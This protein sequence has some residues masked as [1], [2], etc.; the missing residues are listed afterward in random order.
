M[1][2]IRAKLPQRNVRHFLCSQL[3]WTPTKSSQFQSRILCGD[4]RLPE[5]F[6][7]IEKADV[8]IT[9]PPYCLLERRRKGGDLREPKKNSKLAGEDTVPRFED[10]RKYRQFTEQWLGS[11]VQFGLKSNAMLV[12]WSNALGKKTIIDVAASLGYAFRGEYVWAKRTTTGVVNPASSKSEILLRVYES[13]LIFAKASD[14]TAAMKFELNSQDVSLPWSVITGYH[15]ADSDGRHDHPCHKPFA[16]LEPLIRAW[17][18][19]GDLILDCFTG[20]G[21]IP[22]AATRIQRR[23]VIGIELLEEWAARAN[24]AVKAEEVASRNR[25]AN[26]EIPKHMPEPVI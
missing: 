1:F 25:D 23:R 26:A 21:G 24:E 22:L 20:S 19:P 17:S 3:L 13:A 6:K 16:C 4:A 2:F 15:D 5:T 11:V 18:K 7:L 8:L 9:D 10:V 14:L 12:I